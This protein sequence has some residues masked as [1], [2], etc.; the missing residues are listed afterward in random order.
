[1]VFEAVST[2]QRGVLAIK[3]IV[4]QGHQCMSTPHFLHIKG[5]EVNAGQT[6]TFQ[7]TVNGR[8]QSNLLLYLQGM[9]G[10]QAVVRETKPV[11]SR[12]YVAS[13]DVENTTKGDSGR[14]RCIAQSERGVGV[15]SYADLTVKR[16]SCPLIGP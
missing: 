7:C 12:R 13:F 15:S 11:N 2:G 3:D 16:E 6:A 9:G 5:V 1:V 10:R 14:Y 4:L 8:P